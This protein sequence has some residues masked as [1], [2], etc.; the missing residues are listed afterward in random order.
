MS[1]W[2]EAPIAKAREKGYWKTP[3]VPPLD[4][5]LTPVTLDIWEKHQTAKAA[6]TSVL[7][8]FRR[9]IISVDLDSAVET[10]RQAAATRIILRALAEDVSGMD[11]AAPMQSPALR[12]INGLISE[13]E[14]VAAF[15]ET[16]V[17]PDFNVYA[18]QVDAA[19]SVARCV[20]LEARV[21]SAFAELFSGD[22]PYRYS[23]MMQAAALDVQGHAMRIQ[24]LMPAPG[25]SPDEEIREAIQTEMRSGA[26]A[27]NAYLDLYKQLFHIVEF[28]AFFADRA[29]T[30]VRA[31]SAREALKQIE[32]WRRYLATSEKLSVGFRIGLGAEPPQGFT[33]ADAA[34]AT[35]NALLWGAA[36]LADDAMEME[37]NI[38]DAS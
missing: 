31:P 13:L 36:D 8:P 30:R 12:E 17:G 25:A 6:A 5:V 29:W 38:A 3:F 23:D 32:I 16:G 35:M 11:A 10:A 4:P 21:V 28:G 37:Q 9:A 7:T 14:E 19:A 27:L 2:I 26:H 33:D 22:S 15:A 20:R 18:A 34:P 1:S 24:A